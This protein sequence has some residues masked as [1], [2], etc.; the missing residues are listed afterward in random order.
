M[1]RA[2]SWHI[3]IENIPNNLSQYTELRAIDI[4]DSQDQFINGGQIAC[5]EL[6]QM[7]PLPMFLRSL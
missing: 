3:D 2:F 7:P 5:D 4:P 6:T 1:K